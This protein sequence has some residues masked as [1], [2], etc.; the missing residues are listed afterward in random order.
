MLKVQGWNTTISASH[1]QDKEN[2]KIQE[3]H[4]QQYIC[5][6]TLI[7]YI[8]QREREKVRDSKCNKTLDINC[9]IYVKGISIYY[10]FFQ[11]FY[12]FKNLTKTGKYCFLL[13]VSSSV[14]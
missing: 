5:A 3:K 8:I 9:W 11:F 10:P 13:G 4:I 6:W 7:F 1:F 2:L 14:L 12:M